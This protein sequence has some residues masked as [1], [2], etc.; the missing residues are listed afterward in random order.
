M[1]RVYA[2]IF[3][4]SEQEARD[5]L[6]SEPGLLGALA[7]PINH[8]N[9]ARADLALQAA[10][11]AHGI[12]EG[13]TFIEGNKR[14]ALGVMLAFLLINGFSLAASQDDRF[15]M[16]VKLSEGMSPE[17]LADWM[18]PLMQSPPEPWPQCPTPQP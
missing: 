13:Q 15:Q 11:L 5:Q 12:A 10:V 14:T 7:R 1:L 9:Y 8:A 2:E 18:R 17:E 4:C 3:E 6:R 16:M